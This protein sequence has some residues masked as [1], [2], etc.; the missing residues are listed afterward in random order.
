MKTKTTQNEARDKIIKTAC[1]LFYRQGYLATGINQIT[2]G[3]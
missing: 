3:I 2:G 1:E